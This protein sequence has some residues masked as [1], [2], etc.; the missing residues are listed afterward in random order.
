[1]CHAWDL[2]TALLLVCTDQG[3]MLILNN[4]GDFRALCLEPPKP[5]IIEASY[6]LKEGFL[7]IVEDN[8]LFYHSDDEENERAPLTQINDGAVIKVN[9]K[10]GLQST[11]S[12]NITNNNKVQCVCVNKDETTIYALTQQGQLI[13]TD[14]D[15]STY[16]EKE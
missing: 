9:S 7:I 6:P 8:I 3:D 14:I 2:K 11:S 16:A 13:Y 4:T 12:M 15:I 10:E 1:M 5:R